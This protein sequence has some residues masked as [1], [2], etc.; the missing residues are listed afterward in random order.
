[1]G[2]DGAS[3]I[4]IRGSCQRES[5]LVVELT[6]LGDVICMLPA[7]A[8]LRGF[9]PQALITCV[10]QA[11]YAPLVRALD[12]DL[13]AVGPQL[14]QTVRGFFG[15]LLAVRR[16][17]PDIACS[18]SPA[19]RNALLVL[20]SGARVK[21]GYLRFV[22]TSTPYLR[23]N[24]V[25]GP[26]SKGDHK[27]TYGREHI[28]LRST[29]VCAALGIP[30]PVPMP[31]PALKSDA[32]LGARRSLTP[33]LANVQKPYLVIHPFAA[34]EYR[35][36][37]IR[38]FLRLAEAIV[39]V[40]DFDVVVICEERERQRWEQI[41]SGSP[42]AGRIHLCVSSSILESAALIQGSQLLVGND[43]GPLHLAA[44]LGIPVVGLYGPASPE[45][46]APRGAEGVFLHHAVECSPC[47]QTTCVRPADYCMKSITLNEVLGAIR[48]L[49]VART[50]S[51][52]NAHA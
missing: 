39:A 52:V 22:S 21:A 17:Q 28:S 34:W 4:S 16:I 25:H 44:L 50:Q 38:S 24:P 26:S 8:C 5:I 12:L 29:R 23:E 15:A 46:T 9:F 2:T 13:E 33:F 36:W 42:H 19:K 35:E 45:L 43:S 32:L 40:D 10:V 49:C 31:S 20:G 27:L 48:S 51:G 18:M 37:P 6:R 30:T 1:M 47:A 7:L 14:S 41:A 3:N 11:P